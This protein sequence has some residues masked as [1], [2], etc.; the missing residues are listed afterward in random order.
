[1]KTNQYQGAEWAKNQ[2]KKNIAP[3]LSTYLV[4]IMI[5]MM[6]GFLSAN[7]ILEKRIKDIAT[8]AIDYTNFCYEYEILVPSYDSFSHFLKKYG[9]NGEYPNYY[10]GHRR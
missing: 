8:T 3:L 6:I 10:K 1:M 5:S 4:M 2:S 7:L 9:S